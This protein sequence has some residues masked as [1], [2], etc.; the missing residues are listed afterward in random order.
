MRLSLMRR[1]A[2]TCSATLAESLSGRI[3]PEN[4]SILSMPWTY[5][6]NRISM[7][8]DSSSVRAFMRT[9]ASPSRATF[10]R[11]STRFS[12]P[13]SIVTFCVSVAERRQTVAIQFEDDFDR[14]GGLEIVV[15][16]GR[17]DD[18]VLLDEEPRRLQADEQVLPGDD[19]GFPLPD[20]RAVPHAPRLSLSSR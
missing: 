18:F 20:F 14:F 17:Q 2:G 11:Q 7:A 15:D 12:P 9:T 19:F 16:V 1:S 3:T 4:D 6:G 5:T 8:S 13:A 10:T